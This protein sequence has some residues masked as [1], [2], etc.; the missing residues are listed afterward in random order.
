MERETPKSDPRVTYSARP[1]AHIG[2]GKRL[3]VEGRI[4]LPIRGVRPQKRQQSGKDLDVTRLKR[5]LSEA[6]KL[7][8]KIPILLQRTYK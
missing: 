4:N 3:V 2:Q 5:G 8:D 1:S 7:L 6:I